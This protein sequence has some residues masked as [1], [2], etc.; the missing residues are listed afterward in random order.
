MKLQLGDIL[1]GDA[2]YIFERDLTVKSIIKSRDENTG[3][4]YINVAFDNGIEIKGPFN[5]E[6]VVDES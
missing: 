5:L 3:M 4:S 1:I 6:I 2:F